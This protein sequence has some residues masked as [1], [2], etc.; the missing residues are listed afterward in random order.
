MLFKA[1]KWALVVSLCALLFPL[2]AQGQEFRAFWAD[3]FHAVLR[4]PSEVSQVVADARGGNYNA[5]IVEVRKR[6]SVYC[7][8]AIEPTA[9]DVQPGFD[10]LADLIAKAHNTANG[11]RIEVHAWI[12]TYPL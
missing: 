10:P 11:P 6:G 2:G 8:S 4:N 9:A 3:T 1:K 12:V 7:R 5:I